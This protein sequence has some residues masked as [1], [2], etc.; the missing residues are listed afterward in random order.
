MVKFF[1][2]V[3][4]FF[5]F[6][7]AVSCAAVPPAE[8]ALQPA[9]PVPEAGESPSPAEGAVSPAEVA[10]YE[11]SVGDLAEA[12]PLETFVADKNAVMSAIREL[13]AAMRNGDA[14][15]WRVYL[16]PDSKSYLSDPANMKPITD[17]LR[18]KI[19]I[20]SDEEYF[21]YVFIPSRRGRTI[22]EIRYISPEEIKA[23]EVRQ[24]TDI[25]YYYFENYD[26]KWLVKLDAMQD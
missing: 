15:L 16:S 23:V 25:I 8:G 1:V 12:V 3:C 21:K 20:Q 4:V 9:L 14:A 18:N 2:P 7:G 26:G 13:E 17:R 11:R 22:D 6:L 24:N 5:V 19:R 10:E